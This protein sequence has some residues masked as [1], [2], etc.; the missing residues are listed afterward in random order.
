[1]TPPPKSGPGTSAS[2]D[3]LARR[4]AEAKKRVA[5]AQTKLS[6]K[7]NPYMVRHQC[8]QNWLNGSSF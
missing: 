1:M 5:E 6:I 4:V 8:R 2:T 3:D 7:D